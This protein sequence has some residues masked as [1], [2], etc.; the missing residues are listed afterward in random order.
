MRRESP[1]LGNGFIYPMEAL[2]VEFTHSHLTSKYR[3]SGQS[4]KEC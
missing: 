3:E 4:S 1:T 2:L